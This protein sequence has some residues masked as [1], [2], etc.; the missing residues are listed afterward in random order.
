L[1]VKDKSNRDRAVATNLQFAY[2]HGQIEVIY[3]RLFDGK[4]MPT[5]SVVR[6]LVLAILHNKPK[7]NSRRKES[8]KW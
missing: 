6:F 4:F 3:G 5:E 2:L 8:D 1:T 7:K